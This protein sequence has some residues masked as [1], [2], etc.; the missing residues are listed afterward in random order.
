MRRGFQ[1]N[2]RNDPSPFVRRSAFAA[3]RAPGKSGFTCASVDGTFIAKEKLYF[4]KL[5]RLKPRRRF[6]PVAK[7]RERRRRHGFEDVDLRDEHLHDCAR[8]FERMDRAEEIAGRKIAFDLLK[9]VE[10]L[11]EPQFVGLMNDDEQHLVVL[12]GRGARVLKG[13]QFLEIEIIGVRQRRHSCK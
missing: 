3:D 4:A 9:L 8:A 7:T 11:L 5:H 10:Q 1:E 12:R 13:E 6:Q 2:H